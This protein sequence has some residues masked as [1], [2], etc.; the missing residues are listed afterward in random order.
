MDD[1]KY[2]TFSQGDRMNKEEIDLKALKLILMSYKEHITLIDVK[3][4]DKGFKD[5][6]YLSIDHVD[7]WENKIKIN[8]K[9]KQ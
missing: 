4:V 3:D 1:T 6:K 8:I 9:E 7:I 2:I 5:I